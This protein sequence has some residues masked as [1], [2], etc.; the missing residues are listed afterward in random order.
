MRSVDRKGL[1]TGGRGRVVG[2]LGI[3]KRKN[4]VLADDAPK[5]LEVAV[6][7]QLRFAAGMDT[8]VERDPIHYINES[9]RQSF[10]FVGTQAAKL[11]QAPQAQSADGVAAVDTEGSYG[12]WPGQPGNA[13]EPGGHIGGAADKTGMGHLYRPAP[14][15]DPDFVRRFAQTAFSRGDM[16]SAVMSG[17]GEMMLFSCLKR[18]V[19]QS[20]PKNFRQSALFQSGASANRNVHGYT[21]GKVVFNKGAVDSAVGLIVKATQNAR[22]T[23]D[24]LTELAE[25]KN[26]LQ[27]GSGVETLSRQYPFLSDAKERELL[28]MYSEALARLNGPEATDRRAILERAYRK[29]QALLEKKQQL[30]FNFMQHLRFLSNR[31]QSAIEVFENDSFAQELLNRLNEYS[32]APPP[33][34]DKGDGR[35]DGEEGGYERNEEALA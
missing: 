23:V 10:D 32:P 14:G 16:A 25:G 4:S 30:R 35:E 22:R 19:R 28:N 29:A 18:T 12:P 7:Q 34:D 15:G 27:E 9:F 31:A 8:S 17:T 33:P 26:V 1:G 21:Q 13:R 3:Q 5:E 6:K 2:G 20:Q 24:M 11:M